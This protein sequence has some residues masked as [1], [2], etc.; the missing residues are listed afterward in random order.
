[1]HLSYK[2]MGKRPFTSTMITITKFKQ[3]GSFTGHVLLKI[4]FQMCS[5][6]QLVNSESQLTQGDKYNTPLT[7]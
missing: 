7:C 6:Q 3:A 2:S 5:Q 4:S 1:M